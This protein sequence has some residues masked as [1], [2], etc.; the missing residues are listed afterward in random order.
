MIW[1][2]AMEFKIEINLDSGLE[3]LVY[4]LDI[5]EVFAE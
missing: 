1:L 5:Y 4:R 2:H 3:L